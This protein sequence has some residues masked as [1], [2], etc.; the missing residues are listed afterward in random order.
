MEKKIFAMWAKP[1]FFDFKVV[2]TFIFILM[3]QPK[4]N[5]YEH[6]DFLLS[7]ILNFLFFDVGYCTSD[8]LFRSSFL[9]THA[10]TTELITV[11]NKQEKI[12]T[13]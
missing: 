6:F 4:R 11:Q 8:F 12:I 3:I 13:Y 10:C 7:L 2:F 1:G 5:N 9:V